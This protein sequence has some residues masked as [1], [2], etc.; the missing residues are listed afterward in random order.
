[1][2]NIFAIA[3]IAGLLASTAACAED[4]TAHIFNHEGAHVGQA[5]LTPA[6]KGIILN[7]ELHDFAPGWHALHFHGQGVCDDHHDHFAKSG[8]H[9]A[10]E[11]EEHGYLSP[12]GP[13]MGDLPNFF[14]HDDGTA[15][16]QVY[17]E[18]AKLD[19]LIDADGAAILIHADP[20]DYTTQPA[21]NAGKRLACGVIK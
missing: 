3:I 12:K 15:K 9:A 21:G 5:K 11:G 19:E 1:M 13:H 14:V 6:T 4:K 10:R 8:G 16:I 17:T 18:N 7:V 20:D 2:K